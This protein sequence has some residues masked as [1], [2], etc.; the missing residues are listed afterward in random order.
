M[1][2]ELRTE[3]RNCPVAQFRM[4]VAEPCVV[5]RRLSAQP[6]DDLVVLLQ[7]IV[8]TR[9]RDDS[10]RV[11]L[12]KELDRIVSNKVPEIWIYLAKEGAGFA[13]PAPAEVVGEVGN[14]FDSVRRRWGILCRH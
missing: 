8:V 6:V 3:I 12:S 5:E 7:E 10:S 2:S 4:L 11:Q 14:S 13:V 1:Q 9:E